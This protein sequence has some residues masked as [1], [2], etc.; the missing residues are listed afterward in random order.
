MIPRKTLL[1][2]AIVAIIGVGISSPAL[3]HRPGESSGNP[4]YG[5]H[6]GPMIGYGMG[7]G[8]CNRFGRTL[9]LP[10]SNT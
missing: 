3:S 7:P 4:Y 10:M 6:M 8:R 1:A 9:P 2:T 5:W